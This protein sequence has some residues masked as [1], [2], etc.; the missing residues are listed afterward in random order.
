MAESGGLLDRV[1]G[2]D[3][4]HLLR[5]CPYPV[6]LVKSDSPKACHRMMAA[7]DAD[8]IYAPEELKTRHQLNLQFLE[9]ASSLA[10]SNFSELHI[11]YAW[12]ALSEASMRGFAR[13]PENE[14]YCLYRRN[15]A[16]S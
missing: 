2:S 11:V 1:F 12:S 8:D 9:M 6:W 10:L 7:V 16:A 13:T 3:D 15:Q 14:I 5:K 4:M